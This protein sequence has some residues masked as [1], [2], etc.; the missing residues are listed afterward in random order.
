MFIRVLIFT[1]LGLFLYR[2]LNA[3]LGNS[4]ADGQ[5][6]GCGPPTEVDDVMIKDPVC[7]IYFPQRDGVILKAAHEVLYFCSTQC[8]DSYLAQQS[9]PH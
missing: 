8:R 6:S 1:I 4:T 5:E 9:K 3:W 2:A 7:G